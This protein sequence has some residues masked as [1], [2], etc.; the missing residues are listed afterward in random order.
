MS[1]K[2]L[3]LDNVLTKDNLAVLVANFW[4]SWNML[5]NDKIRAWEETSKYIFATDTTTT[6]N[7]SLPWKNKTTL[8]KLCQI[9]DNLS[10]NYIRSLFPKRKWVYWEAYDQQSAS[11]DKK[12]AI[13][14]YMCDV[15][16]RSEFKQTI[17]KLILDW[18]DK[19]NCFATVEWRDE[20]NHTATKDQIGYVGPVIRRIAPMDIV[21]NPIAPS[22]KD[23][24]KII[25]SLVSLGEV[26]EIL[27][28]QTTDEN[29]EYNQ[30][31]FDYMLEIR[32]QASTFAGEVQIKD[33]LFAVDGFTSFQAYLESSYAEILTFYGDL[34]DVDGNIFYRN[35]M[36]QIVDRHRLMDARE[37]PSMM[38]KP[39]IYHCGWRVRPDNLWAMGPLDNLVGMQ[40]RIDHLENLKADLF[41]LT[42]FPPL[43]IKGFVEDFE[44]APMSRI[45]VGDDG[46]V[47]LKSPDVNA[48]NA[49]MEIQVLEQKMEE[50]AGAPKEAMGFRTP[51]E[52]TK[53]E[54]QRLENA[55]SRIFQ[56]KLEQFE[57]QEIEP[58]LNAMLELSRRLLPTMEI[59][60][61]DDEFK[62]ITFQQLSAEDVTGN[63]QL[64]PVAARHFAEQ[65]EKVQ[66]AT[67]FFSSPVG[68]DQ[69]VLV[70][71]SG[72]KIAE[73]FID[74]LELDGYGL[75]Q[76]NIRITE[77]AD[78]QRLANSQQ[79][80]VANEAG[81]P[82][83]IL[84]GDHSLGPP[85]PGAGP[86]PPQ[87]GPGPVGR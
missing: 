46:D 29:R 75:F 67:A 50:M 65:A 17:T 33:A 13:E 39:N 45:H 47:E 83:G 3:V 73:M 12:K 78:S 85:K 15:V 2:V 62:V 20:R 11:I 56:A 80:Q 38:G 86:I 72:Q 42:A 84:P 41:D 8:P 43:M 77:Q 30:K 36:F 48:L 60:F 70:N 26:K 9:R 18:I 74:L 5:R 24:P 58:L 81:T 64:R 57:E 63:G 51:G 71:L 32:R 27:D 53:Y 4:Q 14:S 54:V 59:P 6:S 79:E 31:L 66:N 49:N 23:S 35:Y 7:S 19:G 22:F 61:Y 40:Y 34:Y 55:S 44:W 76:P 28:R 87:V 10:A 21:F 16:E 1:G 68:Q 52:K 82:A 25:R 37:N 69:A